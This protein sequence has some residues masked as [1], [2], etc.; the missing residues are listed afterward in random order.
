[1]HTKSGFYIWA[2]EGANPLEKTR[3]VFW[4]EMLDN[5]LPY[6]YK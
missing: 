3:A 2:N 6:G 5:S 1:M 4:C